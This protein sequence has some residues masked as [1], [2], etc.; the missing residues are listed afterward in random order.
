[1]PNFSAVWLG[2]RNL[3]IVQLVHRPPS[4]VWTSVDYDNCS[5]SG[6]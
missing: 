1:V 6:N 2:Y 4:W 3:A 5:V